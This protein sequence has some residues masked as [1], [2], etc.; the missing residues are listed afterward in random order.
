MGV[1]VCVLMTNVSAA[2]HPSVFQLT[3]SILTVSGE[4]VGLTRL[5]NIKVM[6]AAACRPPATH[7]AGEQTKE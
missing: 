7:E 3:R 5:N 6:G 4:W 2:M 1:S